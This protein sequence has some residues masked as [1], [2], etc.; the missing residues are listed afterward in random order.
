MKKRELY[1]LDSEE[2]LLSLTLE[3]IEV[4]KECQGKLSIKDFYLD[5][6]QKLYNAIN[7]V[8]EINNHINIEIVLRYLKD[9]NLFDLIIGKD[10]NYLI[11]LV[12]IAPFPMN[13]KHYIK[14]VKDMAYRRE[15]LNI[16]IDIENQV[17]NKST[18][19]IDFVDKKILSLSKN[20]LEDDYLPFKKILIETL[21]DIENKEHGEG[22]R[23][24]YHCLDDVL[25]GFQKTDVIILAARTSVG[26]TS[27]ALNIL[28]NMI[29][30]PEHDKYGFGVFSLEM[31]KTQLIHK[32]I[33]SQSRQSL[34]NFRNDTNK[35]DFAK[36]GIAL[37]R[38]AKNN[39]FIEDTAS[40]SINDIK[41]KARK[42]FLQFKENGKELKFI[43]IDYLQLIR[44]NSYSK[45]REQEIAE[46]SRGI[47]ALAKELNI[48]ILCLAQLNRMLD[49]R[50]NKE[51]KLSDLRES[52]S[53]EMDAD[54]VMFL[55]RV[56][57]DGFDN[58]NLIVAKNR[59]G[60][61]MKRQL[62]FVPEYT[63][64][65]EIN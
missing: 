34:T 23:T 11:R 60:R 50:Q 42:M 59:N 36:I 3:N 62:K 17:Y 38:I 55:E 12:D 29:T 37:N 15:I 48:P 28:E 16:A 61:L 58:I 21:D 40:L 22:I 9:N 44:G 43:I 35:L 31:S 65:Q 32:I 41:H 39:I 8:Y 52:G 54:I 26:K 2:A 47:K 4:L 10:T 33:A 20:N 56:E 63:R 53:I 64:F 14:K 46:V 49:S 51:P 30:N 57:S 45:V 5:K 1:C 13:S 27:F 19:I 24:G 7:E 6:H 25:G 18:D